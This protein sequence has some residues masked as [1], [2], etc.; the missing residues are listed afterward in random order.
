VKEEGHSSYALGWG[1]GDSAGVPDV[2]HG[3]GQQGTST[4]IMLAPE[5]RL[6]VV[7]LANMDGVD[8]SA[9]AVDVLKL[10]LGPRAQQK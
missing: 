8:A 4:S 10:L 9:L 6:G 3:G 7:V 1:T 2:G 5:Q